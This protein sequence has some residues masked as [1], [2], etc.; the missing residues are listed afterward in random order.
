[1]ENA[2]AR[3][4]F[5]LDCIAA[6]TQPNNPDTN[7]DTEDIIES[8]TE[9]ADTA[10]CKKVPGFFYVKQHSTIG[11]NAVACSEAKSP[12]EKKVCETSQVVYLSRIRE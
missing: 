11:S 1:V 9:A 2:S 7:I 6:A 3:N 8:C 4:K 12:A 10:Y 5:I